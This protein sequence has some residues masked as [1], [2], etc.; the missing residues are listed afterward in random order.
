MA[1][2]NGKEREIERMTEEANER[3]KEGAWSNR[4]GTRERE[5]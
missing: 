2:R 5:E 3:A 4:R 1:R